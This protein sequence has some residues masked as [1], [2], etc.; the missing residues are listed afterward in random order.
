MHA[1]HPGDPPVWLLQAPGPR[2]PAAPRDADGGSAHRSPRKGVQVTSRFPRLQTA[3]HRR[4][5]GETFSPFYC[6]NRNVDEML[7]TARP[8][9]HH[10]RRRTGGGC[11]EGPRAEPRAG[12]RAGGGQEARA[13]LCPGGRACKAR[14]VQGPRPAPRPLL[15]SQVCGWGEGG[16]GRLGWVRREWPDGTEQHH[17]AAAG[18]RRRA[19]ETD[20]TTQ[21]SQPRACPRDPAMY[22]RTET[23]P[24][25]HGSTRSGR[26]AS[27]RPQRGQT[28]GR[29]PARGAEGPCGSVHTLCPPRLGRRLPGPTGCAG[30]GRCGRRNAR[31]QRSWPHNSV[32][33]AHTEMDTL[34]VNF[35]TCELCLSSQKVHSRGRGDAACWQLFQG[36]LLQRG[37]QTGGVGRRDPSREEWQCVW[38]PR[39]WLRSRESDAWGQNPSEMLGDEGGGLCGY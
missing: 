17:T 36:V 14:P 18:K 31:G 27:R 8:R 37:V 15:T 39:G 3:P 32:D 23:R 21:Q 24:L 28:R 6:G 29:P 22:V 7:G 35:M 34:K 11:K 2:W 12:R 13:R 30:E 10:G 25:V 19:A 38:V 33:T 9:Q 4:R 16:A 20:H 5:H 1:T 26:A